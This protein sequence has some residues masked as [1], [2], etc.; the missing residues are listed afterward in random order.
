M[1]W[2][3]KAVT[4][5]MSGIAASYCS[6]VQMFKKPVLSEL[7]QQVSTGVT[8]SIFSLALTSIFFTNSD[9]EWKQT[10]QGA[11]ERRVSLCPLFFLRMIDV[12]Q[13]RIVSALFIV[14]ETE[15]EA[16]V[17]TRLNTLKNF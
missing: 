6:A 13:S 3:G 5:S 9:L 14:S 7:T 17:I 16:R 12:W 8:L 1:I 11:S 2:N 15:T 4:L 10:S